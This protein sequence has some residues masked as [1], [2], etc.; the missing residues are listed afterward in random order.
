MY[1]MSQYIIF[2]KQSDMRWH[3]K[4]TKKICSMRKTS[5]LRH[6]CVDPMDESQQKKLFQA[7]DL[8]RKFSTPAKQIGNFLSLRLLAVKHHLRSTNVFSSTHTNSAAY[9]ESFLWRMKRLSPKLKNSSELFRI[10]C[11]ITTD[12]YSEQPKPNR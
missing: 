4:H 6:L 7:R 3:K 1:N 8:S 2:L 10:V 12:R 9:L 11:Y 5:R